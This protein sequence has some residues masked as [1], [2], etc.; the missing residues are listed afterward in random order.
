MGKQGDDSVAKLS[1]STSEMYASLEHKLVADRA[2]NQ[3]EISARGAALDDRIEKEHKL[4]TDIIGKLD[5]KTSEATVN[6][7]EKFNAA[8]S[9]L[10]AKCEQLDTKQTNAYEQVNADLAS[11]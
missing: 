5:W 2:A 3:K 8:C 11:L 6:V 10:K 9:S 7:E 1:A 4:F